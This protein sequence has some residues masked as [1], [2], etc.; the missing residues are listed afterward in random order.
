MSEVRYC[1]IC[2]AARS[3]STFCDMLLGGHSQLASLGEFSFLGKDIALDEL[4]SCGTLVKECSEW[5]KVIDRVYHEKS[6]ELRQ[7]PYALPQW[8][9]KARRV[10]D[11]QQQTPQYLLIRKLRS[12]WMRMRFYMPTPVARHTPIPAKLRQGISNTLYLYDIVREEWNSQIVVDSSK[13]A[14]QALSLYEKCGSS[15]RIILL[16][17]DGRGV[18][19]SRRSKGISRQ[20][21]VG[22]WR[23]YYLHALPLLRRYIH[24]DHIY[25][26][27]YEDLASQPETTL[28]RLCQFLEIHFEKQML[29]LAAGSR[30]IVGGNYNAKMN[31]NSRGIQLDERWK[32]DLTGDELAYFMRHGGTLNRQLG[33]N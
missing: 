24:P 27:K 1:Y 17:R 30:H 26:L 13:Q 18:Y 28:R 19:L 7:Q 25:M 16:T 14:Y 33:Y 31:R 15:M 2:S 10:V 9:T 3:G 4:C 29:D 22:K 21:S 8:D 6:I 12:L 20:L 5:A 32:L 23:H 11:F